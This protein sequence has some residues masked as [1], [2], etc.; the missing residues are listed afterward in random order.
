M[1]TSQVVDDL[2]RTSDDI[3]YKIAGCREERKAAFRLVYKSYLEAGLGEPNRHRMRVTPYHLLPSTEVFVAVY[4]GQTIFTVSLITD[5]RLGLPM[6]N[7]YGLE[8]RRRREQGLRVAEVSCLADRRSQYRKCFPVFMRLCRLTSQ[9]AWRQG[10]DQLLVAVHPRHARFYRRFMEFEPIGE[11]RCYP[12]VR[13]RPAIA[14]CL[15]LVRLH[16]ERTKAYE[17]LFMPALPDEQ[18]AS[19][20]LEPAES[21]YFQP[22]VDSTFDCAPLSGDEG[23]A[24]RRHA[25]V[26]C[27]TM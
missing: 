20:P 21:Q 7:V 12:S 24:R 1:S 6:E 11:E 14:L 13:N 5:G 25:A 27:G 9:Y 26:A 17:T 8:V 3:Q 4:Q 18:F 10:L 19:N 16:R 2:A 23:F 22:M 15:D